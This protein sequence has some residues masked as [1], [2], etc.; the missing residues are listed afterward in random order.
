MRACAIFKLA[1]FEKPVKLRYNKKTPDRQTLQ[2]E[3]KIV[4]SDHKKLLHTLLKKFYK[5]KN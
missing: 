2:Q 5:T 4:P 1:L 3:M